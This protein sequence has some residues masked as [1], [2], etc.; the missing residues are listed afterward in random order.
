MGKQCSFYLPISKQFY[1]NQIRINSSHDS[2]MNT[3]A[4][5]PIC[6][7]NTDHINKFRLKKVSD[8]VFFLSI[9]YFAVAHVHGFNVTEDYCLKELC[10][11]QR[12][13]HIACQTNNSFAAACPEKKHL[14]PMSSKLKNLL[15][16]MH[17]RIRNKVALGQL[18]GYEPAKRMPILVKL[19]ISSF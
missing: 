19:S 4:M 14:V 6:K 11:P 13:P 5:K 3:I 10:T 16:T 8:P 1:I 2:S 18:Q 12:H 17:N 7:Y 9:A 15:L